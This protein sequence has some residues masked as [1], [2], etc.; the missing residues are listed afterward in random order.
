MI[1]G[2]DLNLCRKPEI[3]ADAAY[4]ILTSDAAATTGNFFIDDE[5]LACHGVTDLD[6]YAVR[7]GTKNFLPDLFVD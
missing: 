1:P 7:P 3:L 5:V 4:F 6:G 2:L